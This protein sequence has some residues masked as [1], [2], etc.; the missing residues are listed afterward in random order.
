V[1][2]FQSGPEPSRARSVRRQRTLDG[3]DR[4]ATIPLGRK[5]GHALLAGDHTVAQLETG[6]APFACHHCRHPSIRTLDE[7]FV[8]EPLDRQSWRCPRSR[9]VSPVISLCRVRFAACHGPAPGSRPDSKACSSLIRARRRDQVYGD[10]VGTIEH[11]PEYK[12]MQTE[13]RSNRQ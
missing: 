8:P 9:A 10:A 13:T 11:E 12:W 7:R 1:E 6:Q 4:S 5:V 2:G 3:E